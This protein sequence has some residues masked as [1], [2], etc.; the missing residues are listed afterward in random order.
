MT[1]RKL[2]ESREFVENGNAKKGFW[3]D[4]TLAALE[5]LLIFGVF[6]TYGAWPVPDVN[7]QY[8]VGKSIHFWNRAWLANDPFLNTPD[9]HWLFYATFGL[10]S[11]LFK[12]NALVW[13]GRCVV[14]FMTALAWR[15][16]SRA[17]IPRRWFAVLTAAAF[18]FYLESFHLAGE[19]IFGGVE[20]K[21][22]AFPFVFWGLACFLEGK[23]NRAW[24]LYGIGSAFHVLVGG[25]AV[26]AS[27]VAWS[28]DAWNAKAKGAQNG[29]ARFLAGS[30]NFIRALKKTVPGLILGGAI[31]LLGVLPALA[32]DS[33]A[34]PEII[35]ES[36]QIYVF[37]RLAHH[38]VASSLPWTFQLR[39][40]LLVVAAASGF[41]VALC[42][43]RVV[44]PST[45][46]ASEKS[47]FFSTPRG[48]LA[49]FVGAA[50]AFACV[51]ATIDW[52]ANY[53][54][55]RELLNDSKEAA[56]LL[57]YYWYRLSDWAVPLGLVFF[58]T[59]AAV[60]RF[61]NLRKEDATQDEPQDARRDDAL[62]PI[63]LWL[64]GALSV[65]WIFRTVFYKVAVAQAR[66]NA[67][68][69][70]IPLPKPTE[71]VAFLATHDALGVLLLILI[72]FV[73]FARSR[74]SLNVKRATFAGLDV[75][76]AIIVAIAPCWRLASF[77]DL[78]GTKVV[79]RSAPPKDSI[80]DGWLDAC[81]WARENTP[82]KAIFLAPRGCD[83]FKWE[84][85]RAEAGSW[86]EIPQ[87]ARSIVRW[88][89]KMEVFYANPGAKPDSPMRWNQP[90]IV[91]FIN[92][93]RPRILEE[94]RRY[95]YQYAILETPPYTIS[96]IP[97]ATRRWKE[98]EENDV[99][100]QNEQFVVLKL[101]KS[102][103]PKESREKKNK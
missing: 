75:W 67:V 66:A 81:R 102:E 2:Q 33:G 62:A 59:S 91:V 89:R 63:L 85:R 70:L 73:A 20:G 99:V 40:L 87:D 23:Y 78:R 17:W 28:F 86:K 47:R 34:T 18:A 48:R 96:A 97:E 76:L 101:D 61:T 7:E 98:F 74:L 46:E 11:L 64:G 65:Y 13:V 1:T 16:L 27:L 29:V 103:E 88:N 45:A 5:L 52:G 69:G 57:R 38:L 60:D 41:G 79:P 55:A 44:N 37:E 36:R 92:K 77:V 42:L 84:A 93:G 9:S 8:Y 54:A 25:W 24:I 71:D 50:F 32:L 53:L 58:T 49:A 21:G 14:W 39:F 35:R 83:S 51:G 4:F 56:S 95:G 94:S 19:W 26:L 100:Y 90:L 10:L 3:R 12:Q 68:D 15:R 43:A 30:R 22:F 6:A 82:E 31:S 80:A 72:A